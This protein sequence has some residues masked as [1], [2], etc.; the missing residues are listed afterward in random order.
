MMLE[1]TTHIRA[2]QLRDRHQVR[3]VNEAAFERSDGADL[4]DRLREVGAILLSLVAELDSRI[5][6]HILFSRMAIDTVQ[7]ALPPVSLAP[8][9]VHPKIIA[10]VD[11]AAPGSFPTVDCG[12]F[13]RKKYI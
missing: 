1:L 11:T 13:S 12:R 2:G 9:A 4:V 8:M 6:G 5:V 10:A 7:G 3:M